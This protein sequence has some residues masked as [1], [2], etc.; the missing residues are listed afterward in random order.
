MI[1]DLTLIRGLPGSGKSTLAL[2]MAKHAGG[3]HYE[4]DMFFIREGIYTFEHTKLRE[5][6][7]WCLY[8]TQKHLIKGDSVFV[9]NTFS[10]QWEAQPY[11]DFCKKE[12]FSIQVIECQNSFVNI[13]DVPQETLAKMKSRWERIIV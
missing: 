4:A 3:F 6:H 8:E 2:L 11:I 13:H 1:S 5:A 12:M 10:Q 7:A 9:S